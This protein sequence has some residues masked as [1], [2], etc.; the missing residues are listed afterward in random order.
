MAGEVEGDKEARELVLASIQQANKLTSMANEGLKASE[1]ETASQDTSATGK[2]WQFISIR[3]VCT[4]VCWP[5][6]V[7]N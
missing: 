7:L 6:S 5:I 2:Y 4:Y 1:K 3:S